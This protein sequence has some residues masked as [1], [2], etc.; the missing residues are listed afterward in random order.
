MRYKNF[1]PKKGGRGRGGQA[2]KFVEKNAETFYGKL[3]ASD[4][5]FA[6]IIPEDKQKFKGDLFVPRASVNG[7]LDGDRVLFAKVKNTADEAKV[8]KI[9]ARANEQIIGTFKAGRREAAVLPDNPRLPS[10]YVP[11]SMVGGAKNG[12]KVVC[13]V[14]SY[15][16]NKAPGGKIVE[17]L[18]ESGDLY[19]E[20]TA[21]IR[22]FG[23]RETFP[24]DV[25]DECEKN[26]A[27]EVEAGGRRDLRETLIF[28]IDGEDTRDI[29][30]GISLEI[31]DGNYVLGVHIA[32]V[33]NYVRF[34]TAT[35]KEAYARGTSV[36][37]PD[38]VLPM[39]PKSLSNGACSLNENE[40]RYALSC[41]MTFNADGQRLNYEICKSVI[42]SRRRT[43]Y[44]EIT[45]ICEND[46]AI[47][48]KY[49]DLVQTV[50]LMQ[51][52]CLALEKRREEAGCVSMEVME[53]H[54]YVDEKGE[55]II[56]KSERTI[57]Q[58]IIEQ[59]M[60]SANEAVAEF[61]QSKRAACLYRI[62]ENPSE[63]KAANFFAFLRDLGL[64]AKGDCG[65]LK[66]KDYQNILKSAENKPF[67]TVVN[68]VMLRSMQK[69]R[70][71]EENK[72][73]FGL[74]SVCYCHFT[75]PIRRY[76]DLFV[77]RVLKS[78]LEGKRDKAE[79]FKEIAPENGK[80]CSDRERVADE[81]ERKVDDLY[82]LAYMSERLGEEYFAT[83]SGV[84]SHGIY[85]EL[86][87]SIEGLVPFE[88]LPPDN[89][90]VFPEKFLIKGGRHCFR[91]GDKI[92]IIV[93]DYDLG[94]MKI[95]FG[96]IKN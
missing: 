29:D 36:Y 75:S 84:T 68:K 91:L 21:I 61:L 31:K 20:E 73:H 33:S 40:D 10:V 50:R 83:I 85:C 80:H 42:R 23:L 12:D 72:G 65:D 81:A 89:Y 19:C 2:Q 63:E 74:A 67:Y 66:P 53:S 88:D 22:A 32:D 60:I 26:A 77:H 64:N 79:K 55:I 45:A 44:A 11:L 18:G 3:Q 57:S 46:P 9:A 59:F 34:G 16:K 24:Q 41:F 35:D 43:T 39:L 1:T 28:T 47:C 69:A 49:G 6:F 76:P 94:R 48:R 96:L 15:P 4:K 27:A 30:D 52:L 8:I 90:E 70:Y 95:I 71:S 93:A 92:K 82:K 13:E 86:D 17:I 56:P 58:R 38:R 37:F 5:G 25:L 54:I 7:A 62:H 14:L 87:N 51:D 78:I